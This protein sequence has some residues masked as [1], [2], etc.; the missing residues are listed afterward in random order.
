MK[1]YIYLISVIFFPILFGSCLKDGLDDVEYSNECEVTAVAFEHRWTVQTGEIEG[2]W[3]LH[4]KQMNVQYNI[5]KENHTIIL[6]ITVPATDNSFSQT[7]KDRVTLS[8]LAC[9]FHVSRAASVAPLNGAPPLGTLGD[10]SSK[11]FT[12]RVTSASG[13]Y[14]DWQIRINSFDK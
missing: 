3:T 7:E 2:V 9:S 12:Y 8:S 1:K 13:I 6:D 14:K 10:Y 11:T 5:D 4:F